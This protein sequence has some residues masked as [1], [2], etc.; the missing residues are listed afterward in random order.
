MA[1]L[2]RRKGNPQ[3]PEAK[4]KLTF[5]REN[6]KADASTALEGVL[7]FSNPGVWTRKRRGTRK[8]RPEPK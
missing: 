7:G 3:G 2:T 4:R 8:R 5:G 6:V 1:E